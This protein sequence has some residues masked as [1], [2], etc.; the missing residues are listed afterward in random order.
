MPGTT[1]MG[2]TV[3]SGPTR[4]AYPDRLSKGHPRGRLWLKD[5]P[6]GPL[7]VKCKARL[8][9]KRIRKIAEDGGGVVLHTGAGLSTAAG[10]L[11]FR[12]PNGVWTRDERIRKARS[13]VHS[14]AFPG[15]EMTDDSR[16]NPQPPGTTEGATRRSPSP[17]GDA[18][19]GPANSTSGRLSRSRDRE[20]DPDNIQ[21]AIPT[22]A[23]MVIAGMVREGFV[24]HI[25]SQNVD[26]LHLLSGVPRAQLSELHGNLFL[27][28][29]AECKTEV[30]RDFEMPTAG[31]KP[32]GR[33][34][35]QC[36]GPLTDKT[37]DWE[38]NLPEPDAAVARRVAR[39]AKL[40]LVVGS[41]L[42]M[43]PASDM[44]FRPDKHKTIIINLSATD[45]DEKACSVIRASC[46]TVF[47][48]LAQELGV[49][50][51]EFEQHAELCL[52]VKRSP[53][54]EE[55]RELLHASLRSA[56]GEGMMP[57][58]YIREAKFKVGDRK[59]HGDETDAY[60]GFERQMATS[61][62]VNGG[63]LKVSVR[64]A[65]GSSM[66]IQMGA[67][68][69]MS[70]FHPVLARCFNYQ[71][72][73]LK[74]ITDISDASVLLDIN[75]AKA[76]KDFVSWYHRDNR[77]RFKLCVICNESVYAAGP[78]PEATERLTSHINKCIPRAVQRLT[79]LA[80]SGDPAKVL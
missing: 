57:I 21:N 53:C 14:E 64:L 2:T 69:T 76:K 74:A 48:L 49:N 10:I 79:G 6:D 73:L 27:E 26:N 13:R 63:E 29:C 78:T 58:P 66:E 28:Q 75:V 4:T 67:A 52:D 60:V 5:Q 61:E 34:C 39:Q 20:D 36:D 40:N 32:T 70:R 37:L 45:K 18:P 33:C 23:H 62:I 68:D 11:D 77:P 46:D 42:Q 38:N 72:K 43:R 1:T 54:G 16:A 22:L 3:Q 24:S 71:T 50:V 80:K 17:G 19:R 41:S 56:N 7:A 55:G 31:L 51:P 47:A 25:V 44:P 8:L 15:N 35:P 30:T 9:A 59:L 12:G 65:S